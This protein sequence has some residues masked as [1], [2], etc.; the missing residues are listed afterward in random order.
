[1]SDD[2]NA[3][4][5]G[6][7]DA[8]DHGLRDPLVR[9]AWWDVLRP[10]LPTPPAAVA[11]LACG[12]GSLTLLLAEHGYDVTGV[13]RAPAMLERA[14]AK[15]GDR[16]RL[17]LGDVAEPVLPAGAFDVVLARHVLFALPEPEAVLE[18]WIALLRPGGRLLLVEGSWHTGVGLRADALQGML[19][20]L[21][22]HVEVV[23]LSGIDA[24]WGGPVDDERYLVLSRA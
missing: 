3:L 2:W 13:D 5:D 9:A 6:F 11:D 17:L 1:M 19:R 20:P 23:P 24:L 8:P 15:V 4:A 18:R 21:R 22:E 16:A 10:H 7:D 12:T 14:A